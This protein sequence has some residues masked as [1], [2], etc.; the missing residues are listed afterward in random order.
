MLEQSIHQR[1][2]VIIL[3]SHPYG[4]YPGAKTLLNLWEKM[5]ADPAKMRHEFAIVISTSVDLLTDQRQIGKFIR[6]NSHRICYL[7]ISGHTEIFRL[8]PFLIG[9][10]YANL[11]GLEVV[12][13]GIDQRHVPV[14]PKDLLPKSLAFLNLEGCSIPWAAMNYNLETMATLRLHNL[15]GKTNGSNLFNRII[16]PSEHVLVNLCLDRSLADFKGFSD[17]IVHNSGHTCMGIHGE[18][19]KTPSSASIGGIPVLVDDMALRDNAKYA[20][21]SDLSN[22]SA[23]DEDDDSFGLLPQPHFDQFSLFDDD[24]AWESDSD[25]ESD[26]DYDV[27]FTQAI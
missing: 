10:S 17:W 15:Y 6:D 26:A 22:C 24:S 13:T 9:T 1:S 4:S 27:E 21:D 18:V 16:S 3:K 11:T 19:S 7:S 12:Y 23:D 2:K 5:L 8:D 20:N 25:Y 14:I